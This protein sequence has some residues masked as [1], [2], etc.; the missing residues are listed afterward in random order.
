MKRTLLIVV[1]VLCL[2]PLAAAPQETG[3]GGPGRLMIDS[4]TGEDSFN[5]YCATCHGRDGKGSGPVAASLRTP[6]ADLTGLARR[7]RGTFP[8]TEVMSFVT[9]TGR[10]VTTHGPGDM[11]V[12]GPIFRSLEI[13]DPRVKIRIENI[14]DYIE[15]LQGP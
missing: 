11:P 15:M 6:P 10:P 12:W 5:F 8:R 1:C 13:S 9:G 3:A 4:I 7:N 2:A 14:V